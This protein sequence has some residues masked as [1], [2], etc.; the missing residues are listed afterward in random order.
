MK[1]EFLDLK[2]RNFKKG[3]NAKD[4]AGGK[5]EE[6]GANNPGKLDK[7]EENNAKQQDKN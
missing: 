4:A 5:K 6:G 2:A 7:S 1:R 3:A